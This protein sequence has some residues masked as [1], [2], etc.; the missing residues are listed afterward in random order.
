MMLDR[1]KVKEIL[2]RAGMEKVFIEEASYDCVLA[3]GTRE[4]KELLVAVIQ[5]AHAVYAKVLPAENLP[6]SYWRCSY[7]EYTPIG[8]YAFASSL[9]EL[10]E[11]LRPKIE[12]MA[13]AKF[14]GV[15]L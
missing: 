8:L 13:K 11:K 5:G 15:E 6:P 12:A 4:G 3:L 2:L 10:S 1:E 14:S 9:D 7:I